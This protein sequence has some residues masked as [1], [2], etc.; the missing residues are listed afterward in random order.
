MNTIKI[1]YAVFIV[2]KTV[3]AHLLQMNEWI[4]QANKRTGAASAMNNADGNANG[5]HLQVRCIHEYYPVTLPTIL[6]LSHSALSIV[7]AIY[8]ACRLIK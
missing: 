8:V 7:S 4:E 3:T 5:R 1:N 6:P 2:F